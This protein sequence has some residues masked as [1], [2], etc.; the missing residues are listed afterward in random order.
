MSLDRLKIAEL[1]LNS[2]KFS[3]QGDLTVLNIKKGIVIDTIEVL[4]PKVLPDQKLILAEIARL[5]IEKSREQ[6]LLQVY[7]KEELFLQENF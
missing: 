7:A 2:V 5:E 4:G 1:D 3:A 6:K